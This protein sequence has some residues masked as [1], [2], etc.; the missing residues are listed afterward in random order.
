MTNEHHTATE[1]CPDSKL[2]GL[3]EIVFRDINT[4]NY[5]FGT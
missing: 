4:I 2:S 5:N 3:S 1:P